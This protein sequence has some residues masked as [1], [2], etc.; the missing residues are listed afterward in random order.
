[1]L[2]YSYTIMQNFR[3]EQDFFSLLSETAD[4]QKDIIVGKIIQGVKEGDP[5]CMKILER[6]LLDKKEEVGGKDKSKM[7]IP[8]LGGLSVSVN[9]SDK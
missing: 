6:A 2:S 7:P 3:N 4:A 8:I 1:V 5:V 9:D